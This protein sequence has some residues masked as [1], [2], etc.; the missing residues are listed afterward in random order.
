MT[1]PPQWRPLSGVASQRHAPSRHQHHHNLQV[2]SLYRTGV[3]KN[4]LDLLARLTIIF[5][6]ARKKMGQK[7][8]SS[9]AYNLAFWCCTVRISLIIVVISIRRRQRCCY[10]RKDKNIKIN[11]EK[12]IPLWGGGEERGRQNPN[13]HFYHPDLLLLLFLK[14]KTTRKNIL[15]I[16]ELKIIPF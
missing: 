5:E 11:V 12:N 10:T 3:E 13:D 4:T 14:K 16:V 9:L 8:F 15:F 7:C 6:T 1:I 2:A